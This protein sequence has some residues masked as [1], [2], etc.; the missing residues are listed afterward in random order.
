MCS[1]QN[2][3]LWMDVRGLWVS[4]TAIHH[5]APQP[6]APLSCVLIVM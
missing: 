6:F 1:E 5:A 2:G 4:P 3:Y